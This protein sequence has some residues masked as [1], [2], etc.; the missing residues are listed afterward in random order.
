MAPAVIIRGCSSARKPAEGAI[1]GTEGGMVLFG[2]GTLVMDCFKVIHAVGFLGCEPP[3]KVIQPI[4]QAIFVIVQTY[5]LWMSCKHCVQ[6]YL[7][8]TR[9]G[10]MLLIIIN[11]TVWVIAVTEEARHHTVELERYLAQNVTK[12]SENI[13]HG[14]RT[15]ILASLGYT[16]G[17]LENVDCQCK[18]MCNFV[19]S[20]YYYLYPFNIEYNLFAATLIYIMW[21]NVARKI[22]ENASHSHGI[23]PAD[24]K[25]V[26]FLGLISGLSVLAIGLV[27]FIMYEI[28]RENSFN[29]LLSLT[30]FYFFHVTSLVIMSLAN[31]VGIIIFHLDKRHMDNEK[32]P[33][34]TLDMVLLLGTTAA[35]YAIS[36]YS[37]VAMVATNPHSL[38]NCLTL[39]YSLL[40][41]VQHSLQ[42]VLIIEG[43]HRLPPNHSINYPDCLDTSSCEKMK[44]VS[45][46]SYMPPNAS[47][48]PVHQPSRRATFTDQLKSHLKKRKTMKDIYMFLFLSNVIFWI[49]PAFGARIRFDNDLEVEFYGFTIW[50]I[51]TNICLPFGIFYRMHSAPSRVLLRW[52]LVGYNSPLL[53]LVRTRLNALAAHA[54]K[55]SDDWKKGGRLMSGLI[56]IHIVLLGCALVSSGAF[57]EVA[58]VERE[59]LSYLSVLMCLTGCW[60]VTY[61]LWTARYNN[62][63]IP[64]DSHAG[65]IWLRGGLVLFGVCTLVLDVL[66]I[67]KSVTLSHC[68]SP[69]KIV[70]PVIQGLFVVMQTYFL[71]V[72]SQDCIQIHMNLTRCGLMLTLS[73]NLIIWMAAVTDESMHQSVHED[74]P[75][76]NDTQGGH[77]AGGGS[78]GC[79]C[80]TEICKSFQTGYYYLYPFNIE[81]S[82]FASAMAYV[83]WKNV[84]RVLMNHHS[85][86]TQHSFNVKKHIM[87]LVFGIVLLVTGLGVFIVYEIEVN[88]EE[89]KSQALIMFYIFNIVALSLMSASS[90]MALIIY[91][92]DKRDMDGHKNPTRALDVTL[93]IGA[94]LGQICISYYSIIAII[95]TSPG[96][97]LESM[98]LVYALLMIVQ[99][100][101]QNVFIIE[102]LHRKPI[103]DNFHMYHASEAIHDKN[104]HREVY[105]NPMAIHSIDNHSGPGHVNELD[106]SHHESNHHSTLRDVHNGWK[107]KFLREISLFLLLSNIIFWIMPAF[108]A[109]PQFDNGLELN[110]YGYPMWVAIVNIGLP[111][112]IFYRMHSV[113]S[114][115]EVCVMS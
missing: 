104:P 5:F 47:H 18:F 77:R 2:T 48:L 45:S 110:F 108:G 111:F 115:L 86:H 89:T 61:L 54:V 32:N 46:V 82:L 74:S 69:L 40:M 43:L 36:Y 35:Q 106:A 33:T 73:T 92:L 100:T 41:I 24:R 71:W 23:G 8:S 102:G 53:S 29:D 62:G 76:V 56:G 68:E 66:K 1:Q 60:M 80:L 49:M 70:H 67:G 99:L 3:V 22:D 75:M 87:G 57:Y 64:K 114:L 25:H 50:A 15:Q 97:V 37:I 55:T 93:L 98:N 83:M 72:S 84:G 14:K 13:T 17:R 65:P 59:V 20:E 85:H 95:A 11:L 30:S 103:D 63:I 10:L 91:R 42:N 109:R 51:I 113:A 105:S 112:G 96:N 27:M 90:L 12:M 28:G 6:I 79:D 19:P 94:A 26:P 78:S 38:L 7:N 101:L 88:S 4:L 39:T 9:C 44:D 34:R 107:S 31:L 52:P 16:D 58:V 81:Y 21:K